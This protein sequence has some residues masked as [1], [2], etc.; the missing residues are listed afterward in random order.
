MGSVLAQTFTDWECIVVDDGS[1]DDTLAIARNYEALDPRI[2]VITYSQMPGPSSVK[3][4]VSR[5]ATRVLALHH[6]YG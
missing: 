2:H 5:R 1:T 3:I 4:V 6:I